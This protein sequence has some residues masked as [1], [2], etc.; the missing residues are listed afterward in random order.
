[1]FLLV[2]GNWPG[3][4][5]VLS[6]LAMTYLLV[7]KTGKRLTEKRLSSSKPGYAEYVRRTSG[8]FPLPPKRTTSSRD[9]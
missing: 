7:A 1:M 9:R 2:A 6:P 3:L 8:F 5:T 4:L